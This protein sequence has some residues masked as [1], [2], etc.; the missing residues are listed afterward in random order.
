MVGTLL[1]FT[2]EPRGER[3]ESQSKFG[4]VN[5]NSVLFSFLTH[6]PNGLLFGC[7]L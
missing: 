5:G 1:Q 2:V 3:L 4:E 7:T 6:G